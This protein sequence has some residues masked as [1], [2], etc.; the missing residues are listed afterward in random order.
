VLP[1]NRV[2]WIAGAALVVL[3]VGGALLVGGGKKSKSKSPASA[4]ET[5]RAL[6]VPTDRPRTV[7]IPPCQTPL[8]DTVRQAESGRPTPGA[9]TFELPRAPGVRTLLVPHCQPG[10]GATNADGSVPSLAVVLADRERLSEDQGS[11]RAEGFLA[12]SQL[13]LPG[14]SSAG[15]IIVPPCAKKGAAKGRDAVLSGDGGSDLAVAPV[16]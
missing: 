3:L 1:R 12:R 15:T 8:Q 2:P 5:A 16:C 10:T 9:T 4:P 6:V 11:I 13:V 14:G 7:V